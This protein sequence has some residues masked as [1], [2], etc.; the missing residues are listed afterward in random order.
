M[1]A[2]DWLRESSQQAVRPVY[3]VFGDDAYLARESIQAVARA[4]FPEAESE[5]A[6]SRFAGP[7]TALA[8]VLD[9]LFTLPFFSRKRLVIVEDADPFVTKYRSDLEAYVAAPSASGIF[10]LQT[11][12]WLATTKLAKLVDQVGLAIDCAGLRD[13]DAGKI[14][15][16]LTEHARTR[17][18]AQLDAGA[19]RLLIDLV[20]VEIGILAAEV[21]K[22][23]VYAGDSRR[24]ARGDVAKMV[25]AGRVETIWK[26]LDAATTGQ[27]QTA[28]KLLDDL[29]ASGESPN[30][31]LAAISSSLVRTYHAGQL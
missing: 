7:V 18:Q 13:K 9:E 31:L 3:I 28:L 11:K 4:V 20:G 16:W 19:A 10:V 6:I 23:A 12:Q 26:V 14:V 25:G 5:G 29:L 27:G 1:N 24:I 2:L 22:L 15:A 17:C 8:D 30:G 21:E